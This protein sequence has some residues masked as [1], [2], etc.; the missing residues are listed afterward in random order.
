MKNHLIFTFFFLLVHLCYAQLP[1]L[2]TENTYFVKTSNREK[3]ILKGIGVSNNSW[4]FYEWP[5]SDSLEK[6]GVSPMIRPK[7]MKPFVFTSEDIDRI[8]QLDANVIRYCFNHDLFHPQNSKRASNISLMRDHISQLAQKGKY[9]IVCMQFCPG[10]DVQ[11]ETY[12]RNKPPRERIQSVF[13]S[14]SVFSLWRDIWQYVAGELKDL[15]AVTGY[16]LISEP[17]RPA[18]ADAS[19]QKLIQ[20]YIEVIDSIRAKDPQ[21]IVM[22]PEFNSREANPGEQYWNEVLGSYVEDQGEQGTIWGRNWLA[23]PA[24]ISNL[25]YVAHIYSPYEFTT[26]KTFDTFSRTELQNTVKTSAE[27]AYKQNRPL[28]VSEYGVNYFHTLNG[29][30]EKRIDY[31][32]IIHDSFEEDHIST[33]I[34]QYKDLITPWVN[35]SQTFGI[36]QHYY[37]MST[38]KKIKDNEVEYSDQQAMS[39]AIN[40]QIYPVLNQYFIENGAFKQVSIVGNQSLFDE[41]N[42]YFN[43]KTLGTKEIK[44]ARYPFIVAD[45]ENIYFRNLPE[46]LQQLPISIYDLNGDLLLNKNLMSNDGSFYTPFQSFRS[47]KLVIVKYGPNEEWSGK[48]ILQ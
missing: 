18:L 29:S 30:D 20:S 44:E 36:W 28:Y 45:K 40:S 22:V 23:L 10:L 41:L 17:K 5:V 21:H 19:E 33:A 25:V 12:E 38:I 43:A 47:S 46:Y 1:L 27:W 7:E 14:D 4:G 32:K 34:W 42:R 39:A 31:L 8:S 3:I 48:I 37:D 13:E 11:I 15:D 24:D 2:T 6:A 9:T 26:G 16:E 35:M